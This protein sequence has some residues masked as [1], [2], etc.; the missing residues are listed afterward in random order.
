MVTSSSRSN[1]ETLNISVSLSLTVTA[2][3]S[4]TFAAKSYSVPVPD[5]AAVC[6]IVAVSLALLVSSAAV[7]V[8]VC[9]LSQ[10]DVVNVNDVG[11]NVK[12]RFAVTDGVTVTLFAGWNFSTTVYVPIPPS[13]TANVFGS[14]V[15]PAASSSVTS[16]ITES[17]VVIVP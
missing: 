4:I 15:I 2:M 11:L 12:P 3:S 16:T 10:S 9:G 17:A 14:T 5:S 13:F 1:D 8:T 7:T 6:V